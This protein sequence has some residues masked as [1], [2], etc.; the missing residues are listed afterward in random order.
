MSAW[1]Y[2]SRLKECATHNLRVARPFPHVERGWRL[3]GHGVPG[4]LVRAHI[5]HLMR[6][7]HVRSACG[8]LAEV[9]FERYGFELNDRALVPPAPK[10]TNL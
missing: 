1:T 6:Q 5:D 9:R 4:Q 10:R 2:S 8:S 3:N 7:E